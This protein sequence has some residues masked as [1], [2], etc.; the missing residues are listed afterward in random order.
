MWHWR[1]YSPFAFAE[2]EAGRMRQGWGDI[3]EQNLEVIEPLAAAK[4]PLT[5]FQRETWPRNRPLLG[6]PDEGMH[7]GD[8][9]VLPRMPTNDQC[10][11][12][13]ITGGY[14]FQILQ[15]PDGEPGLG[16]IRPV[17]LIAGPLRQDASLLGPDLLRALAVRQRIWRLNGHSAEIDR[18]VE[19]IGIDR[20]REL[21]GLYGP[22]LTAEAYRTAR[23]ID[24]DRE[25][26]HFSRLEA[27]LELEQSK[28]RGPDAGQ[29]LSAAIAVSDD[30]FES[31]GPGIWRWR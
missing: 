25:G 4:E 22:D 30:H 9:V 11:V 24:P 20:T 31:A 2:I 16:H 12:V 7:S 6:R 21:Q 15:L 13:R 8:I 26:V 17:E 3:P 23:A 29:T 18:L 5:D 27:E 28:I 14:S 1:K 10:V 19:T